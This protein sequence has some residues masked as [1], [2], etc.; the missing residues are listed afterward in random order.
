MISADSPATSTSHDSPI[1]GRFAP[2]PSGPLH[3]GSLVAAAGSWL[4][5]RHQGGAWYLRID[6]LDPTRCVAGAA[7]RILRTLEAFALHWDGTVLRQS[8]R[9]QAYDAALAQ[10]AESGTTFPCACSRKVLKATAKQGLAGLIYPGTCRGGLPAG[11]KPHVVR[12]RTARTRIRFVD[13][14]AGEQVVAL[15]RV[16]GDFIL[17]RGDGIHAYHLATVLDDA[18]QGITQVVR[19]AD[20]LP[21]T[22][23]QIHLQQQ[24]ALSTPEYAHLPVVRGVDA[25]KLA[26][27]TGAAPLPETGDPQLMH[28]ALGFLGHAPPPDMT[29]ASCATQLAWA[30]EHWDWTQIPRTD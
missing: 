6:D 16:I 15:D 26:K 11:R 19:G 17:L 2:T 14:L 8:R 22:P 7:E 25:R 27:Q 23:C 9:T 1:R 13:R 12:I 10:L 28:E 21:A 18:H 29:G 5:A 20:L 3:F 24:L 30:C 4:A